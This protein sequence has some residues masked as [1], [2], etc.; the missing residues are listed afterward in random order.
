VTLQEA[1]DNLVLKFQSG[2]SIPVERAT[3]TRDEWEAILDVLPVF[4]KV[5]SRTSSDI[6]FIYRY[7]ED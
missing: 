7:Y 4:V 2:N 3:I 6:N 1:Y 5:C